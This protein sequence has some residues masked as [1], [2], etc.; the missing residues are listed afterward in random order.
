LKPQAIKASD[1]LQEGNGL[2]VTAHEEVLAVIDRVTRLC[3]NERIRAPAE[4]LATF[5]QQDAKARLAQADPRR[6]PAE[7]AS[8][9]DDALILHLPIKPAPKPYSQG[10]LHAAQCAD[11]QSVVKHVELHARQPFE[12]VSIDCAHYLRREH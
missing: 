1:L 6:K 8:Y 7:P 2:M 3:V 12:K 5:E 11:G 9:D 10:N 4:V